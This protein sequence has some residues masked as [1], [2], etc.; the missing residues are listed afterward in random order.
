[1]GPEAGLALTAL[2]LAPWD[3]SAADHLSRHPWFSNG[4][5]T[6][7]D[8]T[9]YALAAME[10]GA[11]GWEAADGDH[12]QAFEVAAE[13]QLVTG[14]LTS[15]IKF[16]TGRRR[17]GHGASNSF[18]SGHASASFAA[19]TFLAR[20]T[21]DLHPEL[22]PLLGAG[23]YLPAIFVAFNRVEGH[24]HYPTDVAVGALLGTLV[25]NLVYDAHYP[26]PDHSHPT[27]FPI[28][29]PGEVGLAAELRF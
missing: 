25:T 9:M 2:A 28:L 20:R 17:P 21:W 11:A 3:R 16:A 6:P 26:S 1:L 10:L 23:F 13:S 7:G 5:T 15:S 8:A 18:P 27:L 14:L 22:N 19:A 24:R 29:A 4:S 12:G